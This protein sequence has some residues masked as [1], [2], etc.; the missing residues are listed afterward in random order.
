MNNSNV[1]KCK[2]RNAIIRLVCIDRYSGFIYRRCSEIRGGA[3]KGIGGEVERRRSDR[4]DM[5]L[6]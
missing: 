5:R 2:G 1:V 3:G 4:R 6:G